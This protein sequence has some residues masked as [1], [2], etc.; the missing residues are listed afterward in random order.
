MKVLNWMRTGALIAGAMACVGLAT[1]AP[2]SASGDVAAGHA[3]AQRWCAVC[4]KVEAGA[5]QVED[6]P[7]TFDSVAQMP[8]T[9]ETSLKV[10]LQT[11]H[12]NMPNL[13]LSDDEMKDVVAYIL[14]LKKS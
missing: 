3:L 6:A 8:S 12:P 11:S 1:A 5:K 10:W 14:S 13:R 4:H 7:P 9:T 2:V